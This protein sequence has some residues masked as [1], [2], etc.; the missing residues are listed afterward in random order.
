MALTESAAWIAE[1]LDGA[2]LCAWRDGDL[3]FRQGDVADCAY[4]L[5]AG[6]V[7]VIVDTPLG[8]L[9]IAVLAPPN[10]VGEIALF[11]DMPRSAS[12]VARGA[13]SAM[14]LTREALLDA[15]HRSAGAARAIISGLGQRLA[16]Q[17]ASVA[18]LSTA[19]RALGEGKVDSETVAHL[20]EE[21]DR[22]GPLS[23][24]FHQ[25]VRAIEVRRMHEMELEL[26]AKV[27]R[28]ILPDPL[29]GAA[30]SLDGEM[31]AA[32]EIGGDFYDFFLLGE[33]RAVFVI[34]DVSGKGVPASLFAASTRTALRSLSLAADGP[35]A[36]VGLTNR[37]L[38]E[39]NKE[40]LFVTLFV[41]DLDL[42]TGLLTY[43]NAG[44]DPPFL[45][46]HDGTIDR[47]APNG[48]AVG[49]LD[50]FDYQARTL[51]LLPSDR[52]LAITDGVTDA[53]DAAGSPFGEERL[54]P[55]LAASAPRETEAL[56]TRL[57][58]TLDAFAS[59]A[60]QFDDITCLVLRYH[61]D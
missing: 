60:E 47:L 19:A 13:V 32:K 56:I 21:A 35:A 37:F 34:G 36:M 8:S 44:H 38:A 11:C 39:S 22:N 51:L 2:E 23:T 17:N 46:R 53:I 30:F 42:V 1:S 7:E 9:T 20:L 54:T 58:A 43:C 4:L 24:I 29:H 33:R 27:Q 57:F 49:M 3:L 25:V 59:G 45:L 26:A 48:P 61:P 5:R 16:G 40:N 12:V 52:L 6:E 50:S 10:M 14:R 28:G 15:T 31:R 55:L 18:L 41:G